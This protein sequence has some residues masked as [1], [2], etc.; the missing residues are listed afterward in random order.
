MVYRK[1]RVVLNGQAGSWG[2]ILPG[3]FL[4][5]INDL[6]D[7]GVSTCKIFANNASFFFK[8]EYKKQIN[9]ELNDNPNLISNLAFQSNIVF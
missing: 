1:Q 5:Y 3:V 6:L 9:L 7:G 2:N 8:L 4:I